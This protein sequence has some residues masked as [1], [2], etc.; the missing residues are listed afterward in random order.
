MKLFFNRLRDVKL[1]DIW[2]GIVFLLALIPSLLYKLYLHITHKRFWLICEEPMEAQDNGWCLFNY[3]NESHKE[4]KTIYAIKKKAP[5]YRA[6]K[7][8]GKVVQFSNF[9]HWIYYLSAE[10]NISSQ[11]GGKPN[12]AVCYFLEVYG[13]LRNKRVF[14]QHGVIMSDL[15][16]L[17]YENAKIWLFIASSTKERDFIEETFHYPKDIVVCTGLSRFDYLGNENSEKTI[18]LIPT[19]RNWLNL[20]SKVDEEVKEEFHD[21]KRSE[22]YRTFQSLLKSNKLKNLLE[23]YDYKL[24]FYPHRNAQQYLDEFDANSE[25]IIF[26]S[27]DDYSIQELL[28]KTSIMITDYSS[29]SFD[30]AY[31][32]KPV[33]YYQFDDARFRK[34]HYAEGYFSYSRDGFGP[35]CTNEDEVLQALQDAILGNDMIVYREREKNFFTYHD[36]NNSERIYQAIERKLK[37]AAR[38]SYGYS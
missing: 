6:V 13:I 33:I 29:V 31:L 21:F 38:H 16:Y 30:Y 3:L 35:V 18:L 25:R 7:E 9:L 27:S 37:D 8:T 1:S 28:M 23:K 15:D 10:V 24:F 4:I 20:A 2:A 5:M 34:Y 36:K 22:Y 14:L 19:W 32:L 26:A 12:A 11:K 17:H